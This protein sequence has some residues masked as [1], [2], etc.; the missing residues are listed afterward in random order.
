M[1]RHLL[2]FLLISA[3]AFSGCS[4]GSAIRSGMKTLYKTAV[5]ERRISDIVNDKKLTALMMEKILQDDVTKLLDITAKCYLGYPFVVGQ[6]KTIPEAERIVAIAREVTGKPVVPYILKKQEVEG[7]NVALNLKITTE[8]N[9]RLAADKQIFATNIFV[10]SVQCRVVLL[11]VVGSDKAIDAAVQHA[12]N[13]GGV[14]KVVSFLVST[15]SNRSWETIIA[16][17]SEMTRAAGDEEGD[18]CG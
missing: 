7:C 4:V 11:G 3:F 14:K 17:V 6:C 12:K 9:A 5:D 2:V 8:I 1:K 16:T 15:G 13:T 18:P 10:K